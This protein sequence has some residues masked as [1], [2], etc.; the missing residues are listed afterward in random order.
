[1]E[2]QVEVYPLQTYRWDMNGI[3][4]SSNTNF[5]WERVGVYMAPEFAGDITNAGKIPLRDIAGKAIRVGQCLNAIDFTH[6]IEL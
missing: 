6:L 5:P 1:M 3:F 2:N 4:T